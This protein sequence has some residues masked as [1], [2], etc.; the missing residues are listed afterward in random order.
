M[1]QLPQPE[2]TN[3]SSSGSGSS[4]QQA[5][6]LATLSKAAAAYPPAAMSTMAA[7]R[8]ITKGRVTPVLSLIITRTAATAGRRQQQLLLCRA[9]TKLCGAVPAAAPVPAA[10]AVWR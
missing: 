6:S 7:V 3:T 4:S 1:Q 9:V 8:L 10:A 5:V 2:G